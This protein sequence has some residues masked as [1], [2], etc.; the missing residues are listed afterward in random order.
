M[1]TIGTLVYD[2]FDGI[3]FSLQSIRMHHKNILDKLEFV[4]ID[5]NPQ[6][7]SGKTTKQYVETIPNCRYFSF[8]DYTSTH[9]RNL[10][11]EKSNTPYTMC[12]DPHVLIDL[13]A[14]FRLYQYFEEQDDGDL[15][16]GPLLHDDTIN[17]STHF[18]KEWR[19]QMWGTWQ[20]DPRGKETNAKPFEINAQGC[21]LFACQ[22]DKWLGFNKNFRGFGGEENYIHEKYRQANKKVM[23]LPFL[24]WCHRFYRPNGVKYKL[25]IEDR[26][27]NYFIGHKE[28]GL[29]T[30]EMRKHFGNY[31]TTE[32]LDQLEKEAVAE[33]ID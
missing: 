25:Q 24:R 2:D 14:I 31:I 28:L 15:L 22:T 11:F 4:V 5:N 1:L 27:R 19:N 3:Y 20:T 6:S 21:G 8:S 7:D 26:V 23:C 12:I 16:H 30:I 33:L 13:N 17:V 18:D 29:D 10:I 9:L 32:Q